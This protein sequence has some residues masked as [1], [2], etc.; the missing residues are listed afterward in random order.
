MVEQI[1][2]AKRLFLIGETYSAETDPISTGL[3]IS[4][5]QDA[6]E[7][8]V[9]SV[10][11][12]LDITVRDNE[13]FTALLKKIE[14]GTESK[15]PH[16]AKLIELNKARIGFKHYG[17]LPASGESEKY[18]AYT[19]DFLLSACSRYLSV[20]FEDVSLTSL[21]E[22]DGV[23]EHLQKAEKFEA[24]SEYQHAVSE[25]A[26]AWYLLQRHI[27]NYLPKVSGRLRG[28][29]SLLNRIPELMGQNIR[30]FELIENYLGAIGRFNLITLL[31]GNLAENLFYEK[32]LP[33]VHMMGSG[34]F[35]VRYINVDQPDKEFT[36]R[37]IKHFV[38]VALRV[39]DT[40]RQ[41]H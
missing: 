6:I 18:R 23:R 7:L 29:D 32:R 2:L 30:V 36:E 5:F 9:W 22:L 24:D 1:L 19:R 34:E 31:G 12:E 20:D 4:L 11:K 3:A 14:D 15:L 33:T 21:I 41:I 28:A 38:K 16:R 39:Q 37:V 8:L 25:A 13:P 26:K 10:V 35:R 27:E 40:L 17:N